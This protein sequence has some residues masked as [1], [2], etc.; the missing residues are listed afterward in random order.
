[1]KSIKR[2]RGPS[3]MQGAGSIFAAVFGVIWIGI[4]V[5]VGAPPLFLLF[6]ICFVGMAIVQAV[7]NFKNAAGKQRFSE[8]D[9]VDSREEGD[10][11]DTYLKQ[12]EGFCPYCGEAVKSDYVFCRKCGKKLEEL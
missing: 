5:N 11:L 7:Y 9:I 4:A 10:P 1:M 2:G 12:D 3:M 6:G 8:Y